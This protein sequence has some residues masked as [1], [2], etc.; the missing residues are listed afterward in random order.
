MSALYALPDDLVDVIHQYAGNYPR[1]HRSVLRQFNRTVTFH[2]L[3]N[4]LIR[5]RMSIAFNLRETSP[6]CRDWAME[7]LPLD[8]RGQKRPYMDLLYHYVQAEIV[9]H[10]YY[11]SEMKRM[12]RHLKSCKCCVMHLENRPKSICGVWDE[13]PL[14]ATYGECRCTCR[15]YMRVLCKAYESS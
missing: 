4:R 3:R 10:L 12:F 7:Y 5:P 11:P 1:A 2:R 9:S 8:P 15:H 14:A 13:Q 6:S